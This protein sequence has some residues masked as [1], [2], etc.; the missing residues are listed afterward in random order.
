MSGELMKV[1]TVLLTESAFKQAHGAGITGIEP[2]RD[3]MMAIGMI[4]ETGDT[5]VPDITIMR[6]Y[7]ATRSEWDVN[8][9]DADPSHRYF[10][11]TELSVLEREKQYV[12]AGGL[13]V[14]SHEASKKILELTVKDWDALGEAYTEAIYNTKGHDGSNPLDLVSTPVAKAANL[15]GRALNLREIQTPRMRHMEQAKNLQ[16]YIIKR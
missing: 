5:F 12:S 1:P 7:G 8:Y 4:T 14:H 11:A 10:P 15:I 2:N 9:K 3:H 6:A 16:P 13:R